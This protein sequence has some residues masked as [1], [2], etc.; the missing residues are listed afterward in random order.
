MRVDRKCDRRMRDKVIWKT[1]WLL[2][3]KRRHRLTNGN[4]GRERVR[5]K[6]ITIAIHQQDFDGIWTSNSVPIKGMADLRIKM[7]PE[8]KLDFHRTGRSDCI[9]QITL[10]DATF[11]KEWLIPRAFVSCLLCCLMQC[12]VCDGWITRREVNIRLIIG[13]GRAMA[14]TYHLSLY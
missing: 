5:K 13:R 4:R 9:R 3:E 12:P 6:D 8:T 7:I 11:K 14:D 2:H 1:E 10:A